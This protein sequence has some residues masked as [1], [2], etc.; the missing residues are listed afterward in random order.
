MCFFFSEIRYTLN[1]LSESTAVFSKLSIYGQGQGHRSNKWAQN[2]SFVLI[3]KITCSCIPDRD[4][5]EPD[6]D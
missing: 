4:F 3:F 5:L 6:R 1:Y 2:V